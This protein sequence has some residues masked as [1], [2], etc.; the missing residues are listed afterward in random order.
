MLIE[1]PYCP[2]ISFFVLYH[3]F[4]SVCFDIWAN[5]EKASYR[6]RCHIAGANA[7]LSMSIP[8]LHGK[9]QHRIF[10]D[11]MIFNDSSWQS[12]H[13]ASICS[14]YRKSPY[15]EFYEDSLYPYFHREYQKLFDFNLILFKWI[16]EQLHFEQKWNF[17]N[18]YQKTTEKG[19][20]DL[21]DGLRPNP[22]RSKI[23]FNIKWPVYHQ[24]FEDR[25]G[26]LE[27]LSVLDLLFNEGPRAAALIQ[28]A[29]AAIS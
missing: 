24:V 26:F 9:Q 18:A 22:Q 5:F 1:L 29:A 23:P 8:L 12:L 13:W 2:P 20:L 11:I 28:E 27:N 3:Y 10:K 4:D 25:Y 7:L 21:R 6:N 17:S 15:F 14:A 19:V 16:I